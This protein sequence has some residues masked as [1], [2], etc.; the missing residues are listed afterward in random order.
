MLFAHILRIGFCR[1]VYI[2]SFKCYSFQLRWCVT[3]YVNRIRSLVLGFVKGCASLLVCT[4]PQSHYLLCCMIIDM[5][6]P[7]F[8]LSKL[9]ASSLFSSVA[10]A[11][12]KHGCLQRYIFEL[13]EDTEFL[14]LVQ[15]IR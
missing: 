5:M 8:Y 15:I 14:V 9:D 4:F 12:S 11:A 2:F 6:L 1:V 3:V 10:T 7:T 13:D